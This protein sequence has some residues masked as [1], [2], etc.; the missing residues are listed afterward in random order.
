[1]K[2]VATAALATVAAAGTSDLQVEFVQW[3]KEFNKDIPLDEVFTR[4]ENFKENYAKIQAHNSQEGVSYTM[5]LN[6]F[7]DMTADE[8]KSMYYGLNSSSNSFGDKFV[9]PDGYTPQASVDWRTKGVVTP[10]KDQGQC[11]SCWAFSTTGAVESAV[12]IK[13]G[14]LTSLS[15]QQLVDCAGSSGNQGCNGGL[16]DDAFQWIISQGGLCTE[17]DYPYTARNGLCQKTCSK[18]STISSYKDV[19]ESEDNLAAA[20]DIG[21]VSIAIEADQSS[22]QFYSGGILTAACG[23]RLDH[24]VLAVGYG[25]E[26]STDYWIVK[27]SWGTRWGEEGYVRLLRGADECGIHDAASYP[28]A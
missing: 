26:G 17:E 14:T 5:A 2:A 21:P 7:A 10:V 9:A 12:A 11:G 18:V 6:E 25:T 3:A 15:E 28:I 8:F 24:G 13:T 23:R 4:F 22:F 19:G 20:V 27:N 16:M 1:M